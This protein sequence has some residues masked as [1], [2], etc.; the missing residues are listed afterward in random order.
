MTEKYIVAQSLK[1]AAVY[2][3]GIVVKL[4]KKELVNAWRNISLITNAR[5]GRAIS[6]ELAEGE[7]TAGIDHCERKTIR[8]VKDKP[9]CRG[10]RISALKI[11]GR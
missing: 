2:R 4:V 5:G 7:I 9:L 6:L 11:V 1:I 10:G 3:E 8:P